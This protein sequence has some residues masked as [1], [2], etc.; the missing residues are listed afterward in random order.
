MA[1]K[2]HVRERVTYFSKYDIEDR[3]LD[4]IENLQSYVKDYGDDV[5]IDLQTTGD[6]DGG[7]TEEFAVCRYRLETDEEFAK[8]IEIET[9]QQQRQEEYERREFERLQKKFEGEQ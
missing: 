8:R 2:K 1:E 9:A 3:V 6:F 4:V 5:F 7:Y